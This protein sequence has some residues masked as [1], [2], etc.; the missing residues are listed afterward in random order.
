MKNHELRLNDLAVS[1]LKESAKW[2]MFLSIV[3][4]VFIG[5]MLVGGAF[6]SF[7]MAAMPD[8]SAYDGMGAFGNFKAYL[9]IIYVVCALIYFFPVYYL[10]NY[11]KGTKQ[12][13][14][15]GNEETLAKGLTNLKSHHKFLGIM[16][17]IMIAFYI[18]G[19]ILMVVFAASYAGAGRM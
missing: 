12:A 10:Y 15:S 18:I 11:A 17:I 19:I 4:F 13:L 2:C 1:A 6:L 8:T 3:G 9:G 7:A 16:T 5:L 14:D